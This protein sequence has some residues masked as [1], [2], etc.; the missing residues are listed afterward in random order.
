MRIGR[1]RG[2]ATNAPKNPKSL[3]TLCCEKFGK[4][5]RA[6][7]VAMTGRAPL[8]PA[9]GES[10]AN[11][12]MKSLLDVDTVPR[13]MR[14]TIGRAAASSPRACKLSTDTCRI[15][16]GGAPPIFSSTRA[17]VSAMSGARWVARSASC[18]FRWFSA[19][20]K[21][22]STPPWDKEEEERDG[23]R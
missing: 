1:E 14:R 6:M 2:E 10:T 8:V 11:R 3:P 23:M 18:I 19:T 22:S 17:L 15:S 21:A 4:A 9:M 16:S 5:S 13:E 7:G 20:S 12:F